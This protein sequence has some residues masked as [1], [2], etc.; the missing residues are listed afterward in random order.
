MPS[1]K[2]C[3]GIVFKKFDH[4]A[5]HFKFHV[6]VADKDGELATIYINTQVRY[7]NL[8][9]TIQGNQLP[10][11]VDDLDELDHDS[12]AD[13]STLKEFDKSTINSYLQ[14]HKGHHCGLL[15]NEIMVKIL[16]ILN[17]SKTIETYLKEKYDF[18]IK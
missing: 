10:I 17:K 4:E 16:A 18:R 12:F 9:E 7:N 1:H 2:I 14:K 15:S 3:V 11:T 13:C 5:D 6:V 8:P